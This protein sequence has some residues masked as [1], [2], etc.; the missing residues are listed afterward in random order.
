MAEKPACQ[1]IFWEGIEGSDCT[2]IDPKSGKSCSA[3][4]ECL[5]EFATKTLAN[6]QAELGVAATPE[7]L[8]E[9]TCV[10]VKAIHLALAFQKNIGVGP[11]AEP[12][13]E[14][15]E[16]PPSE[17][18]PQVEAPGPQAEAPSEAVESP[19]Q[20]A[21]P[22]KK[23]RSKT[24]DPKHDAVRWERERK[25]SKLIA[26]LAPN[27]LLRRRY[28][29]EVYEVRVLASGY[30]YQDRKYPTLYAVVKEIT[31][32]I[33]CPRMKGKDGTRKPGTRSLSNWSAA[34]FF[35]LA[36]LLEEK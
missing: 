30:L 3:V 8:A 7:K 13:A 31:G 16:P 26:K 14:P 20:P 28:K 9:V 34:R 29:G 15:A 36:E 27:T 11:T 33:Q 2:K 25:R 19:V 17:E 5:A 32:T 23:Q 10:D 4:D 21:D 22:P 1:G 24:W 12:L 6:I 18:L 35:K